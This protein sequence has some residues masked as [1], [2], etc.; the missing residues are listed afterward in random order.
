MKQRNTKHTIIGVGGVDHGDAVSPNGVTGLDTTV[1]IIIGGAKINLLIMDIPDTQHRHI[2]RLNC[3]ESK[4]LFFILYLYLIFI[5]LAWRGS[6][7][8]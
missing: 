1:T 8:I 7:P 5:A 2:F 4:I 3:F 6:N